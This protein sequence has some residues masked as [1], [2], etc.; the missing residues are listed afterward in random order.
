MGSSCS[1]TR[2]GGATHRLCQIN[3]SQ[4]RGVATTRRLWTEVACQSTQT[5]RKWKSHSGRPSVSR[6]ALPQTIPPPWTSLVYGGWYGK[7]REKPPGLQKN[8]AQAPYWQMESPRPR[9][10]TE[11]PAG[12]FRRWRGP[13]TGTEP[14]HGACT[15]SRGLIDASPSYIGRW[16]IFSKPQRA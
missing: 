14:V 16:Y 3:N 13:A 1:Q 10:S 11:W 4:T 12:L 9:H 8:M 7:E 15:R 2:G 6:A 5:A